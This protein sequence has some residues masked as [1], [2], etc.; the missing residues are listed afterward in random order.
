MKYLIKPL[1]FKY[2]FMLILLSFTTAISWAQ[3][4]TMTATTSTNTTTTEQSTWYAQPWVWVVG[5][6][7]F[8]LL[9][10]ALTRR[11][12]GGSEHTDKVTVTKTTSSE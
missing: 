12:S 8:I 2:A 7:I 4:S 10:V 6:A 11:N 3:D 5:G 9:I 1:S